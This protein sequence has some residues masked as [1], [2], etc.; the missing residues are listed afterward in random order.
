MKKEW[1]YANYVVTEETKGL[2]NAIIALAKLELE[3]K[4]R[5]ESV[6]IE[7][8]IAEAKNAVKKELE[9]KHDEAIVKL[10]AD[11]RKTFSQAGKLA[12]EQRDEKR[13]KTLH[14]QLVSTEYAEKVV[15]EL[16]TIFVK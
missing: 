3:K 15:K 11:R 5:G 9:R 14:A 4:V 13:E 16:K 10:L 2:E 8:K 6:A 1:N 7:N 12:R